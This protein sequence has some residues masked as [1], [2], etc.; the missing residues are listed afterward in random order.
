MSRCLCES[1]V[2]CSFPLKMFQTNKPTPKVDDPT[3]SVELQSEVPNKPTV[4]GGV[5]QHSNGAA[6]NEDEN[7]QSTLKC[8][9]FP[10]ILTSLKVNALSHRD[11][12]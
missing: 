3:Q 4:N 7:D 2:K 5:Q 12:D 8:S 10:R 6:E 9:L 11:Q 1:V